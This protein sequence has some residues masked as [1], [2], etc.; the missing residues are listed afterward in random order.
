M[1][2]KSTFRL[3]VTVC[4]LGA[5]V[6]LVDYRSRF[7]EKRDSENHLIFDVTMDPVTGIKI[8]RG[9]SMIECIKKGDDWFL[10]E[11]VRARGNAAEIERIACMLEESRWSEC[12]SDEQR[13]MRGIDLDDYGLESPEVVV[14]VDTG[15]RS[16]TLFIGDEMPMGGGVYARRDHSDEVLV[17]PVNLMLPDSIESLRER[18]VLNGNPDET[19]R[20]EIEHKGA[21]FIQLVR[22]DGVWMIQ[23]P[24]LARADTIEV[25]LLLESLY[26][27]KVESFLWD[28]RTKPESTA[29]LEATLEMAAGAR[30]ESCGLAADAVQMRI[31][32]WVDGDS[33]GQ[34]LLLGKADPEHAGTVFAKRGENDAIFSVGDDVLQRC[35]VDLNLLR[36]RRI[37]YAVEDDVGYIGL[38][39]G[40]TRLTL[41][42]D[43]SPLSGWRVVEPVQWVAESQMVHELFERISSLSVHSYIEPS[44]VSVD[45][46]AIAVPQC[47]VVLRASAPVESESALGDGT[48]MGGGE[49]FVGGLCDKKECYF[50]KMGDGNE[51]FMVQVG[52]VDWLN[53]QGTVSPLYYRD[54]SMLTVKPQNVRRIDVSA[55]SG[56]YGV[57]RS[58]TQDWSCVGSEQMVPN[59]DAIRALM[60]VMVDLRAVR[61]EAHNPKSLESYGLAA[62]FATVTLGLRGEDNIQKTLLLGKQA[63]DELFY[64]MLRGQDLVFLVSNELVSTLLVPICIDVDSG[65]AIVQPSAEVE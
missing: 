29:S 41:E 47:S 20:L 61:I 6:L 18:S 42:R 43:L 19:I 15:M 58:S 65:E 25:Q 62:P 10:K 46:T 51:V 60:G 1:R 7:N 59:L 31:T 13:K 50:A 12:I 57:E 56:V 33:L 4:L 11:P 40:E 36:D 38:K 3:F 8:V 39:V 17:M 37:F 16:M 34:E 32:V 14:T 28:V 5:L 63:D 64:A 26:D 49:L 48:L 22:Q 24:L 54:R 52:A 30:V 27:L 53:R 44:V 9:G 35:G 21:G 2:F 45:S 23:Q 55:S